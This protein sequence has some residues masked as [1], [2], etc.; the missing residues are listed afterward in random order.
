M[1]NLYVA[2]SV[3]VNSIIV[4]NSPAIA[5]NLILY[6]I[7]SVHDI[8]LTILTVFKLYFASAIV[9]SILPIHGSILIGSLYDNSESDNMITI[10]N[11]KYLFLILLL[12]ENIIF[13]IHIAIFI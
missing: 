11:I 9:Y 2:Y 10:I 5:K 3:V 1:S 12:C 6:I 8:M 7:Y 13:L 4:A